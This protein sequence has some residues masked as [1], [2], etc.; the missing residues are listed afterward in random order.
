MNHLYRLALT[1]A[2]VSVVASSSLKGQAQM[3]PD[4]DVTR[5]VPEETQPRALV[6]DADAA[7]ANPFDGYLRQA[8]MSA[9]EGE[10]DDA[11]IQ[12]RRAD[13]LASS[14][15]EHNHAQAGVTAAA[16]SKQK[17]KQYGW[18]SKPTQY[19]GGRFWA[20]TESLSCVQQP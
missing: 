16:E 12:F 18:R 6:P 13:N 4:H 19:F 9:V 17:F 14:E 8:A 1:T 20:L 11:M 3:F 5:V 10:F 2:A 7:A 15:C